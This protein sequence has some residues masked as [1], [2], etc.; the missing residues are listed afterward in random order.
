MTEGRSLS[1]LVV[2][3]GMPNDQER[4]KKIKEKKKMRLTFCV[5]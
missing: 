1:G 2:L 4:K 5:I 3:L